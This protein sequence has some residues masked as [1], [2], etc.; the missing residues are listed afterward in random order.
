MSTLP[1]IVLVNDMVPFKHL[2]SSPVFMRTAFALFSSTLLA[3]FVNLIC[4]SYIMLVSLK[5]HLEKRAEGKDVWR[6]KL[7]IPFATCEYVKKNTALNNLFWAFLCTRTHL[8]IH[9]YLQVCR[10]SCQKLRSVRGLTSQVRWVWKI[11]V[12]VRIIFSYQPIAGWSKNALCNICFPLWTRS[13]SMIF[14]C[15]WQQHGFFFHL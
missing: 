11:S 3:P 8:L 15:V 2:S 6:E 1:R 14:S 7:G 5:C 12:K 4:Q 10:I 13:T 9:A